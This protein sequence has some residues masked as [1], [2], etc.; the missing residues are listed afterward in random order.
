MLVRQVWRDQYMATSIM[1]FVPCCCR[2]GAQPLMGARILEIGGLSVAETS[3]TLGVRGISTRALTEASP[4]PVRASQRTAQQLHLCSHQPRSS[5]GR[6]EEPDAR[7]TRRSGC[8]HP[9]RRRSP[10]QPNFSDRAVLSRPLNRAPMRT[11]P[12]DPLKR[13]VGFGGRRWIVGRAAAGRVLMCVRSIVR[14]LSRLGH[15]VSGIAAVRPRVGEW[16]DDS[17]ELDD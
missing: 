16:A 13:L 10:C 8:S 11:W 7:H 3:R 12:N 17:G 15:G 6:R 2:A 4:W 14:Q 5:R 1:R 9:T